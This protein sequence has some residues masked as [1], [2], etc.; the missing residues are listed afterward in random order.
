GS[1]VD[2]EHAEWR[3]IALQNHIHRTAN[4]VFYEQFRGTKTLLVFKMVRNY[5]L[6]R[7]Q[8]IACRRGQVGPDSG[9]PDHA[10]A[11]ADTPANQKPVLT[12][13]VLHHLA[14]LGT[15]PFRCHSG[16][17]IEHFNE[18]RAL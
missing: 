10:L 2:L 5:G 12:R 7:A 11:P 14:I 15:E 1:A 17:V 8:G 4:T 18:A 13:N 3:A 9:T 16:G 6:A